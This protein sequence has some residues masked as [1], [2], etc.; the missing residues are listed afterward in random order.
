MSQ[1]ICLLV[2]INL[3]FESNMRCDKEWLKS[4]C[5]GMFRIEVQMGLAVSKY[6]SCLLSLP[7]IMPSIMYVVCISLPCIPAATLQPAIIPNVGS[8]AICKLKQGSTT[9]SCNFVTAAF[10]S[11]TLNPQ[12]EHITKSTSSSLI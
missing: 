8:E 1:L 7:S 11:T 6:Q 3:N 2:C 9:A 10:G 5:D 4:A 12:L